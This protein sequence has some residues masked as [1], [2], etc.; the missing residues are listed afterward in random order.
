MKQMT[1][2]MLVKGRRASLNFNNA[3]RLKPHYLMLLLAVTVT[4]IVPAY[5]SAQ[6]G[7]RLFGD[8]KIKSTANDPTVPK[9][10]TIIVYRDAGGELARQPVS[11]GGRYQFNNIVPGDYEI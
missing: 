3:R 8:V 7:L 6:R 11:N 9:D 10:V 4:L 5:A 2:K 1:H